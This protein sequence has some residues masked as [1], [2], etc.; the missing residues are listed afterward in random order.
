MFAK[1]IHAPATGRP[2]LKVKKAT[3]YRDLV[4]ELI[5]SPR[6]RDTL[7]RDSILV[8]SKLCNALDRSGMTVWCVLLNVSPDDLS[9]DRATDP[10]ASGFERDTHQPGARNERSSQY[11]SCR[12]LY[13]SILKF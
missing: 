6:V 13:L 3:T 11:S 10:G 1:A 7:D 4:E 8:P 9:V 5:E 12:R 2:A